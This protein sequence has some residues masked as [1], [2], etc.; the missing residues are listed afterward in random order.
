MDDFLQQLEQQTGWNFYYNKA[1]FDSTLI[2]ITVKDKPLPDVL[3]QAFAGTGI[4]FSVDKE[5]HV[6]INKGV[7]VQTGLNKLFFTATAA[8]VKDTSN[9]VI[10]FFNPKNK[11][12]SEDSLYLIGDASSGSNSTSG[13][14]IAGYVKDSKSDEPVIGASVY[15][16]ETKTG[17]ATDQYGYF[18][19][20]TTKGKH[21][22]YVQSIGMYDT[23]RQ[24]N[25]RSNGKLNIAMQSQVIG[26]K[27]CNRFV[28]K[29]EQYQRYANGLAKD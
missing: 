6:F 1:Q 3:K 13:V 15:I 2:N 7:L 5:K 8:D 22:L 20:H 19:F 11:A 23:K 27:K 29:N 24:L 16:D 12:V 4:G 26:I 28:R 21:I 17:V 18:S 10:G 9:N 25:V 14:S